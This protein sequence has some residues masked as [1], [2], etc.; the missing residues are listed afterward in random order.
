MKT[1]NQTGFTQMARAKKPTFSMATIRQP[2]GHHVVP[3]LLCYVVIHRICAV[4][5]KRK[6]R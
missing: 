1:Q 2:F 5:F 3:A 4:R 6:Q